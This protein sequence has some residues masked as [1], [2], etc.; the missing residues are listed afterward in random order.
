[1]RISV[2]AD[3]AREMPG[4][5]QVLTG[6]DVDIGP[7]MPPPIPDLSQQMPR[8]LVATDTVRYV[9]E[10]VAI[11][12]S[13]SRAEGADAAEMVAVDYDPLPV[14]ADPLEAAKDEVL[15]FPGAGTNIAWTG[16]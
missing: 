6:A 8:P 11:V 3:A 5:V 7:L 10:I 12:L 15:L 2:D 1:A 4:V 13:E 9:G 16:G 14:V